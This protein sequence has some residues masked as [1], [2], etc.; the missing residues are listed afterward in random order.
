MKA[1]DFVVHE[2]DVRTGMDERQLFTRGVARF[3]TIGGEAGP[4]E[5][6]EKRKQTRW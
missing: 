6:P 4:L 5:V 1:L 2:I 3:A